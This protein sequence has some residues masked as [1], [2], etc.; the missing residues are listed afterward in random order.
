MTYCFEVLDSISGPLE[1]LCESVIDKA[2]TWLTMSGTPQELTHSLSHARALLEVDAPE[3]NL[4]SLFGILPDTRYARRDYER[5]CSEGTRNEVLESILQ[6]TNDESATQLYWLNGAAGTG[7]TTVA[8]TI[9][10]LVAMDRS[11]LTATFFCSRYSRYRHHVQHLFIT[12]SISLA[13]QDAQF[14]EQ[15]MK[16]VKHNPLVIQALPKDQLQILI[17]EPLRLAGLL[18][19]PIIF[20]IDALD[21]CRPLEEDASDKVLG[22]FAEHLHKVPSL[23]VLISTCPSLSL[24]KALDTTSWISPMTSFNLH[25]V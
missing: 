3:Q 15:L 5:L 9:A 14:R 18:G 19:K 17:V 25:D 6:W 24:S 22:A 12:L 11:K 16:A 8:M 4:F 10:D 23:K 20:V 13:A 7:K 2:E 21:E 1:V